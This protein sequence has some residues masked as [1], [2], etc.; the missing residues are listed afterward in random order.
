MSKKKD[1]FLAFSIEDENEL[2]RNDKYIKSRRKMA[3]GVLKMLAEV[4]FMSSH[5]V[6]KEGLYHVAVSTK[7]HGIRTAKAGSIPRGLAAIAEELG[8]YSSWE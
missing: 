1:V 8:F 3:K 5:Y 7:R 4:D 6:P 2:L